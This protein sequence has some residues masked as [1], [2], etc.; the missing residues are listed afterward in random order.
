M[1]KVRLDGVE[2]R[3][4]PDASGI[5][6]VIEP[7]GLSGWFESTDGRMNGGDR[8]AAH[9]A[10]DVPVLRG[11]RT[12]S[13]K[14]HIFAETSTALEAMQD[15]FTGLLAD[16]QSDE[17]EVQTSAGTKSATVRVVSAKAPELDETTATFLLQLFAADPR[18]Y[19]KSRVVGPGTSLNPTHKGRATAAPLI[20]VTGAMPGG[21]RIN[22]PG[23]RQF[24]V[25]QALSSGQ[26]HEID[27]QTGWLTRNGVWQ[28]TAVSRAET[29]GV[30]PGVAST[31]MT[32]V[33]V[34][35]SGQMTVITT[36]TDL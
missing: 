21:Y 14:G 27:M 8:P 32:L 4:W 16:G 12:I 3:D 30:P 19:G 6:F 25:S 28:R 26:T 22:G 36:D 34:S 9:G 17:L 18:R 24:I 20:R 2:L 5:G 33:P 13:V 7:G 35:G 10:F 29:W 11:G 15:Q 23:G 31:P 1:L